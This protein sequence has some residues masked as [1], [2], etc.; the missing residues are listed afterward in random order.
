MNIHT[1][2]LRAV[3][4]NW[5]S[6][7]WNLNANELHDPNEWNADHHVVSRNSYFSSAIYLVEVFILLLT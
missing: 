1:E 7:S 6:D 2:R 5:N 4:A 3:N